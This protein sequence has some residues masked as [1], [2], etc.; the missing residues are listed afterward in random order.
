MEINVAIDSSL[1]GFELF[2]SD[3]YFESV[4]VT[5]LPE[6]RRT[7]VSLKLLLSSLD[8]AQCLKNGE[9]VRVS[10]NNHLPPLNKPIGIMGIATTV[11][12]EKGMKKE[13]FITGKVLDFKDTLTTVPLSP[14]TIMYKFLK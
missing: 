2:T 4:Y 5:V 6:F 10:L 3:C 14:I 8:I 1:N 11:A 7:E 12:T 13:G 9:D